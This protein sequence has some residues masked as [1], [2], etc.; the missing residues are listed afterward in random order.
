MERARTIAFLG[1]FDRDRLALDGE[2]AW[3]S[4]ARTI[5]LLGLRDMAPA[6]EAADGRGVFDEVVWDRTHVDAVMAEAERVPDD[7]A[8][9]SRRCCLAT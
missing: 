6:V 8:R 5:A 7:I 2:L 1:R 9:F 4:W 3:D